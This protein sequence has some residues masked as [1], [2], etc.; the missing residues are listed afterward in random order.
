M[1]MDT[2]NPRLLLEL[3]TTYDIQRVVSRLIRFVGVAHLDVK[4]ITGSLLFLPL[5]AVLCFL[6]TSDHAS[7]EP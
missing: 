3:I 7:L 5:S 1:F 2:L 4:N 6:D